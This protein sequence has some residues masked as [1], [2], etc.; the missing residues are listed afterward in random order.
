VGS[1]IG[2]SGVRAA[3]LRLGRGGATLERFGQVALPLGAVRDGEVV[4]VDVVA[5]ALKELWAQAKFSTRKVIVGVANQ[6]V[7]V[8]QVDLPWLPPRSCARAW[9]SRC[10]TTSRCRSSTRSST[11]TRSRSSPTTPA[12]GCCASCSSRPPAR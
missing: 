11:C 10:R 4:D 6:K 12:P 5:G 7:V 2:T 3:E 1:D 9:P 8:R